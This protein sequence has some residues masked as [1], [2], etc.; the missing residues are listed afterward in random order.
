MCSATASVGLTQD[1]GRS[2]SSVGATATHELGHI[3]N[4]DHDDECELGCMYTLFNA[5]RQ[6]YNSMGVTTIGAGRAVDPLL[7]TSVISVAQWCHCVGCVVWNEA[8]YSLHPFAM[9][10]L[11]MPLSSSKVH[12]IY[13]PK[14]LYYLMTQA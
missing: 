7:S 8:S 1:T 5:C 3:M 4:M 12:T 13:I 10:I 2:E 11:V 6:Q 9:I 14:G